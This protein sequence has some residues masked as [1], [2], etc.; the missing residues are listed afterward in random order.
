L[1]VLNL[2]TAEGTRRQILRRF[3]HAR[4]RGDRI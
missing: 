3:A 2:K 1:F 4:L